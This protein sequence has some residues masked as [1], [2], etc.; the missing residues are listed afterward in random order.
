MWM[1]KIIRGLTNVFPKE[2]TCDY[3]RSGWAYVKVNITTC[4]YFCCFH[5]THAHIFSIYRNLYRVRGQEHGFYYRVVSCCFMTSV[6]LVSR[7][8]IYGK[9]DALA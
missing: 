5:S 6:S 9:R 8:L 1:Q 7:F 3:L 2:Y 4:L